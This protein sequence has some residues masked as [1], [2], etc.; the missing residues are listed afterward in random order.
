MYCEDK[1]RILF[2]E[3][4]L[5]LNISVGIYRFCNEDI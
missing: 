2:L 4:F 5:D 1:N 3:E